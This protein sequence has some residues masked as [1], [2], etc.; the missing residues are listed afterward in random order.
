MTGKTGLPPDKMHSPRQTIEAAYIAA[1]GHAFGQPSPTMDGIGSIGLDQ[2][3]ES[4]IA[5]QRDTSDAADL[6]IES[7][8]ESLPK[9]E[10]LPK[11]LALPA[12][13]YTHSQSDPEHHGLISRVF[14][15]WCKMVWISKISNRPQSTSRHQ[16]PQR[17]APGS[18]LFQQNFALKIQQEQ[19]NFSLQIQQ[20]QE[21]AAAQF[22]KGCIQVLENLTPALAAAK[23]EALDTGEL[24]QLECGARQDAEQQAEELATTFAGTERR[25]ALMMAEVR[26]LRTKM[27]QLAQA[28]VVPA[29]AVTTLYTEVGFLAEAYAENERVSQERIELQAKVQAHTDEVL[30]EGV[31]LAAIAKMLTEAGID[32][33]ELGS[34]DSNMTMA[35]LIACQSSLALTQGQLDDLR[36]QL[37][38][39]ND[40]EIELSMKVLGLEEQLSTDAA[41]EFTAVALSV[42]SSAAAVISSLGTGVEAFRP[43]S[44]AKM[45]QT[46]GVAHAV[47]AS[48]TV[49]VSVGVMSVQTVATH[50]PTPIGLDT[51]TESDSE[52]PT[53]VVSNMM[54]QTA[55]VS[56][57]VGEAQTVGVT[58]TVGAS[59]TVGVSVGDAFVQT[60]VPMSP[61]KTTQT[62]SVSH[63]VGEAQTVGVTHTGEASQT[64]GVSVGDA[65]VQTAVPMS[66]TKT[67]QAELPDPELAHLQADM[68]ELAAAKEAALIEAQLER[69]ELECKVEEAR[70]ALQREAALSLAEAKDA[71]QTE[72][73]AVRRHASSSLETRDEA[74]LAAQTQAAARSEATLQAALQQSRH[75]QQAHLARQAELEAKL[76]AAE[77]DLRA[78]EEKLEQAAFDTLQKD[79]LELQNSVTEHGLMELRMA[80][81]VEKE[82]AV[83]E[84]QVE[85]RRETELMG[86]YL[87]LLRESHSV[88]QAETQMEAQLLKAT[89]ITQLEK[90]QKISAELEIQ[91]IKFERIRD[92]A[93][94][95]M[96]AQE[97][98]ELELTR[99]VQSEVAMRRD[100]DQKLAALRETHMEEQLQQKRRHDELEMA[101]SRS[102]REH[103]AAA[104]T[105]SRQS[106][107]QLTEAEALLAA[108]SK[109]HQNRLSELEWDCQTQ[110]SEME[111]SL[112]AETEHRIVL[113]EAVAAG[114]Q[115]QGEL[116]S[117]LSAIQAAH[118]AL[119]QSRL[120]LARRL[121]ARRA[122]TA[123]LSSWAEYAAGNAWRSQRL[124]VAS[125]A[126]ARRSQSR[127]LQEWQICCRKRR[128]VQYYAGIL[129][130][131]RTKAALRTEFNKWSDATSFRRVVTAGESRLL[132]RWQ[133]SQQA[134]VFTRWRTDTLLTKMG[135]FQLRAEQAVR[136]EELAEARAGAAAGTL[137]RERAR[138]REQV[139]WRRRVAAVVTL[140]RAARAWSRARMLRRGGGADPLREFLRG[141]G[142]GA[143]SPTPR[144]PLP[145]PKNTIAVGRSLAAAL[146]MA[147]AV[148]QL[149]RGMAGV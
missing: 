81:L 38:T 23:K 34:K 55:S 15:R 116:Q 78:M 138:R 117:E 91:R 143:R 118:G 89:H 115:K 66:P 18:E 22:R 145:W 14:V 40:R 111:R 80:S 139:R 3:S 44:P 123:V 124:D 17:K 39:A 97:S 43:Q 133:H 101:L 71:A 21:A 68:A 113:E 53:A 7:I 9:Y 54:T 59:Q 41:H 77:A 30:R 86:N 12:V 45:T 46:V 50:T 99:A 102:V 126:L 8:I 63:T 75:M 134:K 128:R 20:E 19:Q 85:A 103:D 48:Q 104:Q 74:H 88:V 129:F 11:F 92:E 28:G 65:F 122:R 132:C 52:D 96:E 147:W 16:T 127:V 56:H 136:A 93:M 13:L 35:S 70:D 121:C 112:A 27:K 142:T 25:L 5:D 98:S 72:L 148:A 140:Q 120:V 49:G 4:P 26:V 42:Q 10:S 58:H 119:L 47:G 32:S 37:A 94:Q 146:P 73:E 108:Q 62:A 110:L 105:S 141:P 135:A 109:G 57:T 83:E 36:R 131:Q 107:R 79:V 125:R 60:A 61:T 84:V 67:T 33:E 1:H 24:L 95:L 51:D 130:G 100:A 82:Q 2:N 31:E 114:E 90:E 64:V 149:S 137:A 87:E 69:M 106:E 29:E 144:A 6:S 76:L